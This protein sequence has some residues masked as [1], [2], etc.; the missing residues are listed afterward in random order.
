MRRVDFGRLEIQFT[1]DDPKTYTRPWSVNVPFELVPDTELLEYVCEN[2][3]DLAHV[4][5]K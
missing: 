4:G 3:R 5:G 1:F 2:D